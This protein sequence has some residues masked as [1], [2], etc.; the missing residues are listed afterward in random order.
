M[1][2]V[3][4]M[5]LRIRGQFPGRKPEIFVLIASIITGS[6]KQNLVQKQDEGCIS[7]CL[8]KVQMW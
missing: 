6:C 7:F 5:S 2:K 3:Q 8:S 1:Q 4:V